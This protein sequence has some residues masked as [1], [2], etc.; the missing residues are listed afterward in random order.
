MDSE[1]KQIME[2]IPELAYISVKNGKVEMTLPFDKKALHVQPQWN[3]VDEMVKYF[4]DY[5]NYHPDFDGEYFFSVYDGWREYSEPIE[6]HKREYVPWKNIQNKSSYIGKGNILEIRFMHPRESGN[7]YPELPLQIL[8]YN[9]H[10]DDRNSLLVP[11]PDFVSDFFPKGW[12]NGLKMYTDKVEEFDIPYEQK[13][14][15]YILWRGKKNRDG[16]YD[17][18]DHGFGRMHPR[19]TAV[20][21][22]TKYRELNASFDTMEIKDI[23]KHKYLLDIDGMVS[24]WSGFYWKMYSNSTVI[25]MKSHWEQWY[26]EQLSPFENYIPCETFFDIPLTYKWCVE[27]DNICKEI[28]E[29]G[30]KLIKT[31]TYDYAVKKYKFH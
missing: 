13:N 6:P 11:D 2:D 12:T 7:I 5:A 9:R 30:I 10:I 8:T 28:A 4:Q 16:G 27:N 23:L 14:G 26:Y 17:A 29:N 20:Y 22:S 3:R 24:A 18:Y 31:L 1:I 25:K 21:F 19:I 15:D